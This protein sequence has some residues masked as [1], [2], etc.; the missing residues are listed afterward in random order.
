MKKTAEILK[1]PE[2]KLAWL[3]RKYFLKR[4]ENTIK[5]TARVT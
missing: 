2:S 3:E 5:H 4:E 1:I